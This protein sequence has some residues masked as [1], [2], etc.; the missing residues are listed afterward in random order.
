M[1][2]ILSTYSNLSY[3]FLMYIFDLSPYENDT[4]SFFSIEV[5][6]TCE[7]GYAYIKIDMLNKLRMNNLFMNCYSIVVMFEIYK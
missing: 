6:I 4:L 7:N 2:G 5:I 3:P 1:I